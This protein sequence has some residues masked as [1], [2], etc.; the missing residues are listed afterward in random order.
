MISKTEQRIMEIFRKNIFKKYTIREILRIS[1]SNSY[2]Q[3]FK[4]VKALQK[5]QIIEIEK[6]G[7]SAICSIDMESYDAIKALADAEYTAASA[8]RIPRQNI[9]EIIDTIETPFFI[10]MV[11]GSYAKQ[12]Q[13]KKSDLDIAMIVEDS[14]NTKKILN[15]IT[16]KGELLIPQAHPYIFTKTQFLQM[17][18]EKE[19]NYGKLAFENHLLV[20]GAENYYLIIKEA[21]KNGFRG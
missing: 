13:T 16:N 5:K 10:C 7:N 14:Q 6:R 15:Q 1:N 18:L 2:N 11:T 12:T 20:N 4:A 17:L 21:I 3:I 8:A 9:K 19:A